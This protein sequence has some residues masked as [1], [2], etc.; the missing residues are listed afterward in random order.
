ML[1][2]VGT[3]AFCR[4]S[5]LGEFPEHPDSG[6][7]LIMN[8]TSDIQVK[9]TKLLLKSSMCFFFLFLMI[10]SKRMASSADHDAM[11]S[12]TVQNKQ[13]FSGTALVR[14]PTPPLQIYC[15][16]KVMADFR[17]RCVR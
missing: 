14:Q 16:C 5:V 2:S 1:L 9:P 4:A 11:A 15:A 12:R 8:G 17:G 7:D 3:E 6:K 10:K 13:D